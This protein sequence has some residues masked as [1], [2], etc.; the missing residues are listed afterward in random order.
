MS[1]PLTS[2][3]PASRSTPAARGADA[4]PVRD[5]IAPAA[6]WIE[7]LARVGYAAKALL[8]SVVGFLAIQSAVGNGGDTTGSRGALVTL[9][10]HE[11]GPVMLLV[12][13]AGLFGYAVWRLAEAILDPERRGSGPKGIALRASFAGR[14]LIHAALGVQAVRLAGGSARTRGQAVEEWTARALEAPLGV[15]L[16]MG[17]GAA[18]AGYG[19]YQIYRAW[20]AKL[21]RNLNLSRLSREAGSWLIKVCRFGIAARGVVFAICG[22]YLARAGYAHNARAAADTGEALDAIGHQPFGEWML[23]AVA[24]GL[25]AYGAYE[26]V[27]ARYRVIR[28][29]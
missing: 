7:R 20:A 28:P 3:T 4:S 25:I 13:A 14:G 11:Y 22:V 5:A 29:A 10:R 21:S 24:A 12:I 27:Q 9:V 8:Y 1:R 26:I 19:L 16:V 2:T 18:V 17:V 15:W 23:A 6:T